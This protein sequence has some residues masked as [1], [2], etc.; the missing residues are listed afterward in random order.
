MVGMNDLKKL[1]EDAKYQEIL[2][3]T[4]KETD[5]ESLFYRLASLMA[6]SKGEEAMA[7]L[8]KNRY[9]I[10]KA[11]PLQTLKSDF[12][13]RI[14][15]KEW[16]E[17]YEDYEVFSNY[18]YISQEVEEALRSI[19]KALRVAEKEAS[20][21]LEASLQEMR[22]TL[23]GKDDFAILSL[24]KNLKKED[25][26]ALEKELV[27]LLTRKDVHLFVR[28]YALLYLV[29]VPYPKEV[30]FLKDG[31][32]LRLTPSKLEPPYISAR[33][34]SFVSLLETALLDPS[35]YHVA[36]NILDE[37]ILLSYPTDVFKEEDENLLLS[38]LSLLAKDYLKGK[39]EAPLGKGVSLSEA[40][41]KK[42][43]IEGYLAKEPPLSF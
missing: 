20:L 11:Y 26:P 14:L 41:L 13:L 25:F 28:T 10:F 42:K 31:G 18:P 19:P 22:E 23:D 3:E 17:A 37:Y 6:L 16:D 32:I 15:R 40:L 5:G 29:S 30:S 9:E 1:F 7:L 21:P 34:K 39:G 27:A 43:E 8:E 33:Y 24:L 4:D 35:L 2:D 38:A 36:R 12:S